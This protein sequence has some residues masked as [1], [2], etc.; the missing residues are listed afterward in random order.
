MKRLGED[1]STATRRARQFMEHLVELEQQFFKRIG[2]DE[3][4]CRVG[5]HPPFNSAD[6]FSMS[7]EDMAKFGITQVEAADSFGMSHTYAVPAN[8]NYIRVQKQNRAVPR[9]TE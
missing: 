5:K 2:V 8:I 6:Y 1:R 7:R 3:Q 4:V 9:K